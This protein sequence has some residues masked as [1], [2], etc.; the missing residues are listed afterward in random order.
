MD[1][2]DSAVVNS[3]WLGRSDNMNVFVFFWR[4]RLV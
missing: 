4:N 3:D 2:G 1:V